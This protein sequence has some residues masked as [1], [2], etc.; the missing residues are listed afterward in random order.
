M[1]MVLMDISEECNKQWNRHEEDPLAYHRSPVSCD[2]YIHYDMQPV[3]RASY[4]QLPISQTI[5]TK[6]GMREDGKVVHGNVLED[7]VLLKSL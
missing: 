5:T 7:G 1:V 2:K 3:S 6:N 4:L